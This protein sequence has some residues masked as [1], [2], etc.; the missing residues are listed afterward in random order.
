[1]NPTEILS[2]EHR[3][4]EV[5]LSALEK[6]SESALQEEKLDKQSAEMAID[7]IRTFADGCHHGKEEGSLFPMLVEKGMPK[8]GGPVGQMLHEH[9]QG[10]AFVKSMLD[11]LNGASE[12]NVDALQ[13]FTNSATGYV[14][15]LRS[16][17]AKENNMLFP[18][19]DRILNDD[20]Q[21]RL[22]E[23]FSHVESEHMGEGTHEKYTEIAR[24]LAEKYGISASM[25]HG[26]S[27]GCEH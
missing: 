8:Q 2:N 18:L 14:Q 22:L 19:A 3:V 4:V 26:H 20:D 16:H 15:L 10:R 27:C 24:K 25:L 11:N 12:G 6:I 23:R 13:K 1:M 17:I 21:R 9:E 5:V 7:F